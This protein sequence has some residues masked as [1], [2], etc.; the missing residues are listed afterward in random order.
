MQKAFSH[1]TEILIGTILIGLGFVYLTLQFRALSH[2]TD[3]ITYKIIE[4][5]NLFGQYNDIKLDYVTDKDLYA[6]L[7]GYREYPI[8]IDSNL[9]PIS[10]QDYQLYFSYIKEG[11]YIKDYK[12]DEDGHIIMIEFTYQ[13]HY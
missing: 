1:I 8:R 6:I 10:G 13:K 12:Y 5:G 3:I 4:D 2:L 7:M 11:N 9:V